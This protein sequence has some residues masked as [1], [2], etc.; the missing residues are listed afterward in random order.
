MSRG[1]NVRL[2]ESRYKANRRDWT[3]ELMRERLDAFRGQGDI[4][5]Q[6][7]R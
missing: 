1:R 2:R 3:V 5:S 7:V 4:H 6:K